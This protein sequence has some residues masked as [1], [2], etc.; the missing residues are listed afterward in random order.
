MTLKVKG[1]QALVLPVRDHFE[2][3]VSIHVLTTVSTNHYNVVMIKF[4]TLKYHIYSN[5]VNNTPWY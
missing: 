4:G 1:S 3:H 2:A 5:L